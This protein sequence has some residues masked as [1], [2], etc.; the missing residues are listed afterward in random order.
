MIVQIHIRHILHSF[1]GLENMEKSSLKNAGTR[2]QREGMQNTIFGVYKDGIH[3]AMATTESL[4][5]SMSPLDLH[6][7]EPIN[8]LIG[9]DKGLVGRA[10]H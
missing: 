7:T 3:I 5:I 10:S 6:E 8:S 2:R 9:V 4:N 1:K